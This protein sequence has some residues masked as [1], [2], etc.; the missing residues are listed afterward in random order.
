M[1]QAPRIQPFD[2]GG[3]YRNIGKAAGEAVTGGVEG[4]F[5]G[6][7][8]GAKA[9]QAGLEAEKTQ[10]ELDAYAQKLEEAE[11]SKKAL[12]E[13]KETSVRLL[14]GDEGY[15]AL[16]PER[17][18]KIV[19]G[20]VMVETGGILKNDI[21]Y[22]QSLL[23]VRDINNAKSAKE[24]KAILGSIGRFVETQQ[25]MRREYPGMKLDTFKADQ[26][27]TKTDAQ[28]NVT[29]AYG[30]DYSKRAREIAVPTFLKNEIKKSLQEY[31][32]QNKTKETADAQAAIK[33]VLASEHGA[34]IAADKNLREMIGS[35]FSDEWAA[36]K[37]K[38]GRLASQQKS[39]REGRKEE[40]NIALQ[41]QK[42]LGLLDDKIAS[43]E[44]TIETK[45]GAEFKALVS[46][47]KY[48]DPAATRNFT[49]AQ[50]ETLRK[51]GDEITRYRKVREIPNLATQNGEF[52]SLP[53]AEAIYDDAI[54]GTFSSPLTKKYAP[55]LGFQESAP[56]EEPAPAPTSPQAAAPKPTTGG[57]TAEQEA[58]ISQYE[59]KYPG[60][61][62]DQI[63]SAMQ[64]QNLL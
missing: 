15:F 38:T 17:K 22:E 40:Q 63:I 4:Y 64:K 16:D 41:N 39:G 49:D 58:Q 2:V 59:K 37:A 26:V 62:R 46:T 23:I 9:Q 27:Q 42:V 12:D 54:D 43:A 53:Q 30:E 45:V 34:K 10:F 6:K 29:S 56:A 7:E 33:H 21:P 57:F 14:L 60:R 35:M 3:H 13:V 55:A 32:E 18:G 61:S 52:V 11:H 25:E 28:G 8:I 51:K 31:I 50:R 24:V 47:G 44:K 1:A 20:N 19:E 5:R 48:L 36:Y